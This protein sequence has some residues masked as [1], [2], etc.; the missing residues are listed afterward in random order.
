MLTALINVQDVRTLSHSF[1]QLTFD[2]F[3]DA[4]SSSLAI[5]TLAMLSFGILQSILIV[6]RHRA[7]LENKE[8]KTRYSPLT[9]GL[10]TTSTIGRYWM[11]ITLLRWASLCIII[12]TLRD[13]PALQIMVL[14]LQSFMIQI[15]LLW[16]KPLD[17]SLE[18]KIALFNEAM[19]TTYLLVCLSLTEF[20]NG[21]HHESALALVAIVLFTILIN[22]LKFLY[23]FCRSVIRKDS[24]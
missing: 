6:R 18:N 16:G 20:Q 15:L 4:A 8:F 23:V 12:V 24:Q 2:T 1:L 14:I 13:L 10:R 5:L 7:D 3:V 9:E 22:V 11:A 17:E 21:G 19:A